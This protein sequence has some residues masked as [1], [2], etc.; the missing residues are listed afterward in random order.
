MG[1]FDALRRPPSLPS[2][3][4]LERNRSRAAAAQAVRADKT[5]KA[6]EKDHDRQVSKVVDYFVNRIHGDLVQRSKRGQPIYDAPVHVT[7]V[8]HEPG[9]WGRDTD[10]RLARQ[11]GGPQRLSRFMRDFDFQKSL[12]DGL[13]EKLE[14][15][16]KHPLQMVEF[17]AFDSGPGLGHTDWLITVARDD[18]QE[19]PSGGSK[20]AEARTRKQSEKSKP[21]KAAFASGSSDKEAS[22]SKSEGSGEPEAASEPE[23]EESAAKTKSEEPEGENHESAAETAQA[24]SSDS[25][26]EKSP[27]SEDRPSSSGPS[28]AAK[29]ETKSGRSEPVRTEPAAKTESEKPGAPIG[30][31]RGPRP[32]FR[33]RPAAVPASEP[34]GLGGGPRARKG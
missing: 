27:E 28:E 19:G 4:E 17:E 6:I 10:L 24:S 11:V 23:D 18:G 30:L 14:G 3:E 22:A 5:S 12:E 13:R 32:W 21:A 1:L 15:S 9:S 2:P 7:R 25:G 34:I 29:P 33:P 8:A 26:P 20:P 31:G 16:R